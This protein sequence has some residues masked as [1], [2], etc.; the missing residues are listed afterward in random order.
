MTIPVQ[1]GGL[2]EGTGRE[3]SMKR[4]MRTSLTVGMALMVLLVAAP[5]PARAEGITRVRGHIED[6]NGKPMAKVPVYFEAVDISKRVGPV[7]T[8]KK[9]N[10]FYATLDVSVARRWRVIPDLPGYKTV[11]VQIEVVGS[12]NDHQDSRDNLLGSKQEY[13]Q[14]QFALV[15]DD[16]RNVVNLTVAKEADYIA[17]V[18]EEKK[19]RGLETAGAEGAA[20][21]QGEA[22]AGAAPAASLESL[23]RAKTLADAG[24]HA[25]AIELYR[26]FLVKDPSGNPAAYY[27]YG[28]SLFESGDDAAAE[29]AF[30]KGLE[31]NPEMKGAHF[32]LGTI[33]LKEE[34][35]A[36]AAAEFEKEAL[37]SPDT[38]AVFYNLGQAYHGAGDNDKAIVALDKSVA[39]DP[40][41]TEPLMLLASIYEDKKDPAKR[42]EIYEKIKAVD[43]KNAAILFYNIG[44][45]ARNANRPKEAVQAF[46]KA[47]EIDPAY[48]VAYRELGYALMGNQDFAGALKAFQDYLRLDPKASD[49]KEIQNSIALLK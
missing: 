37:K 7:Y 5:R 34:E 46:R 48:S 22:P 40:T 19:K 47:I 32:F 26:A 36:E 17:A 45:K 49:A 12:G 11:R 21:A 9:G 13:P 8:N 25:Q 23:K 31:L 24:Q 42:D 10:Y 39:L 38:A 4:A 15:G 30:S 2:D 33:H 14:V 16:G 27:Y 18:N 41:K 35:Y 3:A 43:P 6:Y 28:K 1:R 20:A 29:Q 44:A